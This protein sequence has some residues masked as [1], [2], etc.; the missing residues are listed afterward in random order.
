MPTVRVND[1]E[2]FY[3]V[4]GR[5]RPFVFFSETA[6]DGE[7]WKRYQVPEFSKDHRVILHDYRGT[8][9]S[10]KPLIDCTKTAPDPKAATTAPPSAGPSARATL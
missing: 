10:S 1:G 4:H 2:I 6:C 8:G 7:I 3:E 5:G 9:Q